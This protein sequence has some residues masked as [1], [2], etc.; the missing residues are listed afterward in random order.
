MQVVWAG[1]DDRKAR[2]E[3]SKNPARTHCLPPSRRCRRPQLLDQSILQRLVHP[4]DTTLGLAGVWR[5][6]ISMLSSQSARPNCVMPWPPL[7][8]FSPPGTPNACR[9]RRH[10]C[11]MT[12]QIELQCLE[13]VERV[14]RSGKP[15]MQQL[16]G[17]VVDIDE[18]G[19]FGPAVL[20]PPVMRPV[21][22]HQLAKASRRPRGWKTRFLRS[23]RDIQMPPRS[24]IAAASPWRPQSVQLDQLLARQRRTEIQIA[25]A[26]QIQRCI[27]K[28]LAVAPVARPRSLLGNRARPDHPVIG[29]QQ[30]MDLTS[31]EVEQLG[32]WTTLRRSSRIF[33]MTS[34]RCNSFCDMVIIQDMT[35]P[36]A[37]GLDQAEGRHPCSQRWH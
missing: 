18:Q 22:L 14:L 27:A 24:S 31:A 26:D 19:A 6:Q 21:D 13:I 37:H 16:A 25:F 1:R 10:R 9:N 7:A 5:S 23:R 3:S 29:L 34:R 33:W 17:R 32:A 35:T 8:S 4:L 15:Q 30:P 12:L 11:T 28:L 20:E 2:I 36:T